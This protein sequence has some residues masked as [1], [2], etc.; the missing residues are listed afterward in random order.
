MDTQ[1]I[2]VDTK[3]IA[4]RIV[5]AYDPSK[6]YIVRELL[7]QRPYKERMQII[8]HVHIEWMKQNRTVRF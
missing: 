5:Q 3:L 4:K 1:I 7:D 6:A 8:G 2:K